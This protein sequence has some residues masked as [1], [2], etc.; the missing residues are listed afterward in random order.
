MYN[1]DGDMPQKI[2]GKQIRLLF[3]RFKMTQSVLAS[4]ANM[5]ESALQRI[6]AG[7]TNPTI[8]TLF[9]ISNALN[10]ELK[11]LFETL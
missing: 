1:Y 10:V 9:K 2:V 8:K 11:V 3:K 7:R 5:E 6:E 4:K